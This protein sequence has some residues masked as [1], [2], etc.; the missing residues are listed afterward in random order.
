MKTTTTTK[1]TPKAAAIYAR[2]SLDKNGDG[3]GVERQVELCRKLAAKKRWKVAEVYAD[4]SISAMGGKIRPEYDRMLADLEAGVRDAVLCVDL[5]RLTR[6]PAE[7]ET[8]VEIADRNGVALANVSGDTD[9]ASS[10]GRLKARILGAVARQESEKKSERM[11]RKFEQD[12]RRGVPASGPRP[13]G[14]Q[15]DRVTIDENEATLIKEMADRMNNGELAATIA[16]DLNGRGI[17]APKSKNGWT[18][19][20]VAKIVH[21]PRTA[22][23]RAYKGEVVGELK[24]NGKPPLD[25]STWEQ[26]NSRTRRTSRPGRPTAFLLAGGTARCANCG[27]ALWSSWANGKPRYVCPSRTGAGGCG[28]VAISAEPFEK[29]VTR[30]VIQLIT[31]PK[32]AKALKTAAGD[33]T[34]PRKAARELTAAED[35]KAE[36]A[37]DY[38]DGTLSRREWLTARNRLDERIA[39]AT[40]ILAADTGPLAGLPTTKKALTEVWSAATVDWRRAVIETVIDRIEV[41]RAV[42]V[43]ARFD[44]GRVAI[45]WLA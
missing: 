22:G 36:M 43:G 24:V 38:A 23:L 29:M 17:A 26:L 2:L 18:A 45:R 27:T 31:S 12:A 4:N 5:D 37:G 6:A 25:R 20:A 21:A 42:R 15:D 3:L 19:A 40:K 41:S 30:D 28:K 32:F 44:E 9:L 33:D 34:A 8:F 1:A 35:R 39:A 14:Y 11:I 10:D 16:R 7:L 13:F